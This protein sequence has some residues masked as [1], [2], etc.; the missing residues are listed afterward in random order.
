MPE[1]VTGKASLLKFVQDYPWLVAVLVGAMVAALL[2]FGLTAG[3]AAAQSEPQ[4]VG[5][6][7]GL[8]ASVA[9]QPDGTV[10]LTWNPA[11]NAQ[12]YMVLFVKHDDVITGNYAN[13]QMHAFTATQGAISGLDGGAKYYFIARGMRFNW[14]D[15]SQALGAWSTVSSA[16]PSG[17][18]GEPSS[19]SPQAE[20]QT[21]GKITGLTATADGQPPGTVRL[22]WNPAD[23]AQVY[24]V[25]FLKH[26][27]VI[28]GNYANGQMRAFTAT[29]G[30][31]SGLDGG[32]K[33]YF[34]ARGMRFNWTDF[35][36]VLGDWSTVQSATP[37]ATPTSELRLDFPWLDDGVTED[38][39]RA[40]RY[41]REILQEDRA[42]A[43]TLLG[44]PWLADG[45]TNDESWAILHLRLI[46]REDSAVAETLLGFPW[47]ADGV[48]KAERNA[49]YYL[50]LILRAD[51]AKA[52]TLLG[53]SW[54][55]DGVTKGEEQ[56]LRDLAGPYRLD[57]YGL[58]ALA[59]KPWF[60]DGFSDEELTAI[61]YLISIARQ[62]QDDAQAIIGMP[63]LESVEI[64]DTLALESLSEI[65][66]GSVSDFRELMSHPRIKDGITDEET[67][68][69]AVL[70][71]ATYAYAPG[72]AQVLLAETG[73]YIEE[74]LIELP[75][76]GETL[77]AVIRVEDKV[78]PRM[79][80]FE[81]AVRSIERFMGEP[82]PIDYLAL[83]YY[84]NESKNA[85]NNF[86]HLLLMAEFDTVDGPEFHTHVIA[87]EAAHWYWRSGQ[88][89][90]SEGSAEFLR[91]IS[92]HER[93]G[94]SLKPIKSP[95]PYFDSIS[96]LEKANP[97]VNPQ[98][99]CWYSLGQRIFLDLYLTLGHETFRLAFRNLYQ[100]TQQDDPTDDC[101]GI[102][103]NICH[104]A[105]AFK[106]G[107]SPEVI[108][109]VDAVINR[110][111]YG[112]APTTEI[113]LDFPLDGRRRD[114]GR[115]A[116][117]PLPPG[118]F[119]GRPRRC[120]DTL[121]LP[122]ARRWRNQ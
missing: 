61:G 122:L 119:A 82:Y 8:T 39:Q 110:W 53:Y 121:E 109:K 106:D 84:D 78:T 3:P 32:A 35:G 58:S 67:K 113:R 24:M 79:D 111:Y 69:V 60:K 108:T 19:T 10:R 48:T 92:E 46:L 6:V 105:A 95:C 118:D 18:S 112:T 40:I 41:L 49:T 59:T 99:V 15:F 12:V 23:N 25:L 94:R 43:A 42:I 56:T 86:T 33:Y 68:I 73:V 47:L 85:N 13:G 51:P 75:H 7:T 96:E 91:I 34:I 90:I 115:T 70:G 103:P 71:G 21:V 11:D 38:E 27:D 104:V 54:L 120:A 52:K 87:H 22:T 102:A 26:D 74:R 20:P 36:E 44:F 14:S 72:S 101:E 4:T 66:E 30:A 98:R 17:A 28:A 114:R 97:N 50:R 37:A 117:H 80:H 2:L 83:L 81:H 29:Q 76:S 45:V 64:R 65:A 55:A 57:R 89:W 9:G 62:S 1:N 77:L 63:F 88:K 93:V 107:A 5:K 116:G 100:K 16:T 31:I